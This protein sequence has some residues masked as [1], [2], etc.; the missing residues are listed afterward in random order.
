MSMLMLRFGG[1]DHHGNFTQPTTELLEVIHILAPERTTCEV[2]GPIG[3][4]H[5]WVSQHPG[6]YSVALC[7]WN[8]QAVYYAYW[9]Y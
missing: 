4:D 8:L 3:G 2:R 7:P 6:F 9:Q 5:V 1:G